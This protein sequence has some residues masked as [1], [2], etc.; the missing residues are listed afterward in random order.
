MVLLAC[1]RVVV[2]LLDG[3]R[4]LVLVQGLLRVMGRSI[5]SKANKKLDTIILTFYGGFFCPHTALKM[6]AIA[7][8]FR[9][10]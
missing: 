9:L 1:S 8:A 5:F 6:L 4:P 7:N 3:V 2:G 10:V